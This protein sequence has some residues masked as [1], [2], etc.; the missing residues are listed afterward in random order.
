[1]IPFSSLPL[2]LGVATLLTSGQWDIIPSAIGSVSELSLTD[3][4]NFTFTTFYLFFV[5]FFVCLFF[6]FVIVCFT[7]GKK[8]SI[9]DKHRASFLN[10]HIALDMKALENGTREK[11][12][13]IQYRK[14]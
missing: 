12:L 3:I 14:M 2:L 1:M 8:L 7:A 5:G 9:V 4:W 10:H 11:S 13:G 6:F